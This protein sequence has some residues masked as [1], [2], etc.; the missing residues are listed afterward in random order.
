MRIDNWAYIDP[1]IKIE[2]RDT[3]ENEIKS[4]ILMDY[5]AKYT[6]SFIR[7]DSLKDESNYSGMLCNSGGDVI[8]KFIIDSE[9]N[10]EWSISA[11]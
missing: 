8:R 10:F 4:G 2:I 6:D 1:T 3:I 11:I 9:F 7:F 5:V